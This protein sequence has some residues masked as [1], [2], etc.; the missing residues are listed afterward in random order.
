MLRHQHESRLLVLLSFLHRTATL[1][2]L[3]PVIG[4]K[5]V[6]YF[7]LYTFVTVGTIVKESGS[8]NLRLSVCWGK[9][10]SH[11]PTPGTKWKW[12]RRQQAPSVLR[13]NDELQYVDVEKERERMIRRSNLMK[14]WKSANIR[15]L[16]RPE[17]GTA[18]ARQVEWNMS[19]CQ[20]PCMG[21]GWPPQSCHQHL[22]SAARKVV[23][24][25]EQHSNVGKNLFSAGNVAVIS[26]NFQR[27]TWQDGITLP[28]RRQSFTNA[29]KCRYKSSAQMYLIWGSWALQL[30]PHPGRVDRLANPNMY[31]K[32]KLM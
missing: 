8:S 23:K 5:N 27:Q 17:G 12:L 10:A 31:N 11:R 28:R 14:G 4:V 24:R 2:S 19:P 32:Q 16:K 15:G 1:L 6:S 18:T 25:G 13:T 7:I 21:N 26:Y 30:Q 3:N 9:G 22:M 20:L 29:V